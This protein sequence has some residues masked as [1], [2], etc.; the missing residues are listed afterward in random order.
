[1]KP[2]RT[3]K[4]LFDAAAQAAALAAAAAPAAP[5]PDNPP[6]SAADWQDAVASS[7]LPELREK[8]VRRR[9]PGKKP[10]R[11]AIQLRLPPDVL[12]R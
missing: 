5:D 1:M 6:T 4:P 2:A 9:G 11:V 12:A 10:A 7:S 8:L 3:S